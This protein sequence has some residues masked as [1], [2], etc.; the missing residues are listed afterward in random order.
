MYLLI[1]GICS[2]RSTLV[3]IEEPSVISICFVSFCPELL[4][5]VRVY[6]LTPLPNW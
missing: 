6:R 4:N 5:I 2:A 3:L 1:R